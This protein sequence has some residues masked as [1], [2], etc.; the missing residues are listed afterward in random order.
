MKSVSCI[1]ATH[2]PKRWD[3]DGQPYAATADDAAY[4][5]VRAHG[6]R[7]RTGDRPDQRCRGRHG[8]VA[9]TWSPSPSTAPTARRSPASPHCR[10]QSRVATP[11]PV[12]N[13]DEKQTMN[14]FDQ[15][16]EIPETRGL[17][18]RLQDPVGALHPPRRRRGAVQVDARRRR[19]RRPA[20]RG[21]AGEL[22][23]AALD[24]RS[25]ARALRR[26]WPA[27]RSR[28]ACRPKIVGSRPMSF[29]ARRSRPRRRPGRSRASPTRPRTS[30]PIRSRRCRPVARRRARLGRDD[31]LP[32]APLVARPR[33]RRGDGHGAARHGPR[34][35]DLAR[36]DPAL[37][38]C[39][40]GPS[41]RA[42][43]FG[44]R[45]RPPRVRCRDHGRR[46]H[47]RLRRADGGDR[48]ARRQADRHGEPGARSRRDQRWPTTSAS[49]TGS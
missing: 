36:A 8:S 17:R 18:Q 31:R 16:Q 1:G 40:Q 3:E 14:F 48:S 9:T 15:W 13:P 37:A 26:S 29:A 23:G 12:W 19:E 5:T 2:I 39:R 10:A 11:R 35:A 44:L 30:S 21:G 34:L 20:G 28:C 33:R 22:E 24:R 49:T 43:R 27:R 6:P 45:H 41:R 38:R 32:A 46:R 7:R 47:P 25:G 4:A 42:G